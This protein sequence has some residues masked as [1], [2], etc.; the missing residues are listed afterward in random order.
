VTRRV[1]RDL[2]WWVFDKYAT[3]GDR[4][5]APRVE[6]TPEVG[7]NPGAE[8]HTSPKNPKV[9]LWKDVEGNSG[10]ATVTRMTLA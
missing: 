4:L 5:C 8:N 10:H 9:D 2:V 3:R 7:S 6:S 1:A